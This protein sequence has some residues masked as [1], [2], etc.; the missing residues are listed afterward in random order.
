MDSGAGA[1]AVAAAACKVA[2][3]RALL[4]MQPDPEV[5]RAAACEQRWAGG[6]EQMRFPLVVRLLCTAGSYERLQHVQPQASLLPGWGSVAA[7]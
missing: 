7:S 5:S 4:W 6:G 1:A 2:A 3:G